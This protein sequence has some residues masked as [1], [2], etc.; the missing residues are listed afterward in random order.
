MDSASATR[1]GSTLEV[2][3]TVTPSFFKVLEV[4][5]AIGRT[6]RPED[7]EPSADRVLVVTHGAW[8]SRSAA[9]AILGKTL[10]M[11]GKPYVVI[12]VLPRGYGFAA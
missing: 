11:D 12:G 6:F 8:Q 5:P 10:T 4:Q 7:A 9:T 2:V 3:A 1:D